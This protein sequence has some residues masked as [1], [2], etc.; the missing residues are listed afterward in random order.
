MPDFLG[1]FGNGAVGAEFA[2]VGD[3]HQAHAGPAGGLFVDFRDLGLLGDVGG[4][5]VQHEE[6]VAVRQQGVPDGL[7]EARLVEV[8]EVV[9]DG[10]EDVQELALVFVHALD[11]D[12]VVQQ[13]GAQSAG[14]LEKGVFSNDWKKIFRHF[15]NDWK[16]C[17][18]WL[19]KFRGGFF[20]QLGTTFPSM[21]TDSSTGA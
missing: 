3:V 17:F 10:V 2:G 15:S 19:E 4:E 14:S 5:F 1:L 20:K 6:V 21:T 7:V 13:G 18:Q 9:A 8:E 12:V 16:K 11:L